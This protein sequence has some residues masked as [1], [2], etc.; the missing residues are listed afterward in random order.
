MLYCIRCV[1]ENVC[2]SFPRFY[3]TPLVRRDS[4]PLPMIPTLP[5]ARFPLSNT[6]VGSLR[7]TLLPSRLA[8]PR[9]LAGYALTATRLRPCIGQIPLPPDLC[10]SL[11]GHSGLLVK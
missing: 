8:S 5:V 1:L 9:P 2:Q 6:I 7:P 3:V 10:F 4:S 11:S